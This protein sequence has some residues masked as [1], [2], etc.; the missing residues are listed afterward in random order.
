MPT[1][2]CLYVCTL[3]R[4]MSACTPIAAVVAGLLALVPIDE[5]IPVTYG[6][7]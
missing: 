2:C 6:P 4:V 3:T 1:E 7:S 5:L